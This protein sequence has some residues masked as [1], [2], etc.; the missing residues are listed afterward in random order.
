MSDPKICVSKTT[1]GTLLFLAEHDVRGETPTPRSAAAI[2]FRE[3][4]AALDKVP[5]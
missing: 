1:L 2:A 3:A 4:R 5:G